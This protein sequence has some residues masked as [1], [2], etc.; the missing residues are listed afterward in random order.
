MMQILIAPILTIVKKELKDFFFSPIAAIFGAVFLF[1]A[2]WVFFTGFFPAG[3]ASLRFFFTWVPVLFLF[4]LPAVTMKSWAEEKKSGTFEIL[5]TL[6]LS[7]WQIILGKFFSSLLSLAF[8]LMFTLPAAITISSLGDLDWGVVAGGYMGLLFLGGA[9][10]AIGLY[11]SG[12]T[13]NQI[14]AFITTTT[15]LFL[16]YVMGEPLV[17]NLSPEFLKPLLSFLSL[18]SHFESMARGVIDSRDV[19]YYISLTG[20]FLT[21]NSFTL[22]ERKWE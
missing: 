8:I 15:V 18:S 16:L 6:P 2:F 1:L 9:C 17:L 12:L 22:M 5:L 7:D 4:L 19:F 11:F 20:F 14:I 21:L 10:L 13:E 3:Q